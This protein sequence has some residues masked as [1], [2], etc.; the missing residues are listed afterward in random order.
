MNLIEHFI[1]QIQ[2]TNIMR[3]TERVL[4]ILM[5]MWAGSTQ[6]VWIYIQLNLH[7]SLFYLLSGCDIWMWMLGIQRNKS[8]TIRCNMHVW[9]WGVPCSHHAG[10][11]S[12]SWGSKEHLFCNRTS[13]SHENKIHGWGIKMQ[14]INYRFSY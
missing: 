13:Q 14:S 11:R 6:P 4:V 10:S 7:K 8:S 12:S 1:Q 2:Q 9:L 5:T 3:E